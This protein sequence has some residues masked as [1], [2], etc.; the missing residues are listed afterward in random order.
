[1]KQHIKNFFLRGFL[2]ASGGPVVLAI[3]YGILGATDSIESLS[4]GTVCMGVLTVTLMAFLASGVTEVYQME[5]LPLMTAIL[6][7]A[8]VLYLDYLLIY[9][10]NGWL[11][12]RLIPILIFTSV[13]LAGFALVWLLIWLS[14]RA[15]TQKLNRKLREVQS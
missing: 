11:Q 5:Q 9:L 12:K 2:A 14:I 1:M 10:L 8:A 3:V 7:H 15:K 4:P 6:I 13:F